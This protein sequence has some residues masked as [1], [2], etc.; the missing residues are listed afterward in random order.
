MDRSEHAHGVAN[1]SDTPAAS[2]T[3]S[4]T[5]TPRARSGQGPDAS[6]GRGS[7]AAMAFPRSVSCTKHHVARNDSVCCCHPVPWRPAASAN[8]AALVLRW[9]HAAL[10]RLGHAGQRPSW[11]LR[12][13]RGQRSVDVHHGVLVAVTG[14][15]HRQPCLVALLTPGGAGDHAPGDALDQQWPLCT[16]ADRQAP[17]GRGGQRWAPGRHA[18]PGPRGPASL[19]T[20]R[21]ERRRQSTE[22]RVRGNGQES[23]LGQSR[24]ATTAPVR[25]A[26]RVLPGPLQGEVF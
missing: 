11:G 23:A 3:S 2:A 25:T 24:Q 16:I 17:P 22:R 19:P 15:H 1:A 13:R 4:H 18:V 26:P 10:R 20:L 21:W 9:R 7:Q 5:A 14:A 8:S 12:D 6:A